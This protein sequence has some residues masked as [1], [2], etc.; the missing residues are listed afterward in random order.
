MSIW[1]GS[2]RKSASCYKWSFL[3]LGAAHGHIRIRSITGLGRLL[4]PLLGQVVPLSLCSFLC[5]LCSPASLCRPVFVL[6]CVFGLFTYGFSAPRSRLPW[7]WSW[8]WPDSR[9]SILSFQVASPPS[10]IHPAAY[11]LQSKFPRENLL[12]CFDSH[13][14][15]GP[16]SCGQR[17]SVDQVGIGTQVCL[18]AFSPPPLCRD[19]GAGGC[20]VW[21]ESVWSGFQGGCCWALERLR[22]VLAA[23]VRALRSVVGRGEAPWYG[24]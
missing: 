19:A 17:W 20:M 10:S 3:G 9:P 4:P 7:L 5:L 24:W 18:P 16:V 6:L 8:L 23:A 22:R 14:H 12:A 21:L 13:V 2:T 1:T 15:P 11:N